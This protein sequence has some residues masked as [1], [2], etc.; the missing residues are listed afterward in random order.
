MLSAK[1]LSPRAIARKEIMFRTWPTDEFNCRSYD[2]FLR[3]FR[4]MSTNEN[5]DNAPEGVMEELS[6]REQS[7]QDEKYRLWCDHFT[8]LP[9][10]SQR[11]LKNG[12]ISHVELQP[13]RWIQH[14]LNLIGS[15]KGF[16]TIRL[17]G[18][19]RGPDFQAYL[20]YP[21]FQMGTEVF[22]KGMWLYQHDECRN[23]KS[24][25]YTTRER[26]E[27]FLAELKNL[28][29]NHDL[30][31]ITRHV[32]S[33]AAYKH[34]AW[35]ARFLKII[36][37]ISKTYYLPV[38]GSKNQWADERYPKRFYNDV[39]KHSVAD[40]HQSYPEYWPIARLFTEAAAKLESLW[41]TR[42]A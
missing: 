8:S 18:S 23:L 22:L 5:L 36:A 42:G 13:W 28:S 9:E 29:R 34:D 32:E 6:R 40:A 24:D 41:K 21:V 1:I 35:L 11:K 12:L 39:S 19:E 16:G 37:G 3:T 33:I 27:H 7:E 20:P 17:L 26:R 14:G 2:Q 38:T 25:T 15:R 10:N 4:A 31:E 30:L